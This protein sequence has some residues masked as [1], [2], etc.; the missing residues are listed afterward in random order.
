MEY[1]VCFSVEKIENVLS[2]NPYL[3]QVFVHGESTQSALVAI[4]V[5]N[6]QRIRE[7]MKSDKIDISH[8]TDVEICQRDDVKTVVL[9]EIAKTSKK[10]E[11]WTIIHLTFSFL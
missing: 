1:L 5:L 7:K 6:F 3:Q 2:Q 4:A 11:V 8:L 10:A 9:E